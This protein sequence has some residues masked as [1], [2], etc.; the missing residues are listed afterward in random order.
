MFIRIKTIRNN[1]YGYLVENNWKKRQQSSRQ[2]VKEY[3]GRV[4]AVQHQQSLFPEQLPSS[5]F[6][7]AVLYILAHQLKQQGFKEEKNILSKDG[8]NIN[9]QE[10]TIKK[11]KKDIV[12]K[13]N[14]GYL[15][16]HTL[17]NLLNFQA[18]GYEEEAG[19]QLAEAIVGAGLQIPKHLFIQLFEK[20]YKS[21]TE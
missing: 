17:K 6:Q 4:I 9:L 7:E 2:K 11:E 20:I 8:I 12:L 18:E 14:E 10:Q 21:H 3:L 19:L 16:S 1:K 15:C 13:I 5:T